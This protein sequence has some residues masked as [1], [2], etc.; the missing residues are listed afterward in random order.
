MCHNRQ[1][2]ADNTLTCSY[3]A[4]NALKLCVISEYQV[5]RRHFHETI[6]VL[7]YDD[8]LGIGM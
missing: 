2:T 7:T 6:L 4:E 1:V 8:Y 3:L 5:R